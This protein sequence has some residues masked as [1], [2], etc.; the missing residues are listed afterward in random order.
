[1][2]IVPSRGGGGG[3][4]AAAAGAAACLAA[5]GLR[6]GRDLHLQLRQQGEMV[7]GDVRVRTA[8][9]LVL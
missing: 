5:R 4:A 2:D 1:M 7:R 3:A 6:G 9:D 8:Q